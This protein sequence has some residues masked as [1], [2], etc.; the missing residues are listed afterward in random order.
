M[1]SD[2]WAGVVYLALK[3]LRRV[4]HFRGGLIMRIRNLCSAVF[5]AAAASTAANAATVGFSFDNAEYSN[6]GYGSF[7]G[8]DADGN[9]LLTLDELTSFSS[10]LPPES[11]FGLTLGDLSGF[12]S[13][14]L[15]TGIWNADGTGWGSSDFAWYSWNGDGNSV[16]TDWATMHITGYVR[17]NNVPEPVSLALFGLGLAALG[18]VRRKQ[19]SA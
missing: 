3:L 16:N 14:D 7:T 11:I 4:F 19:Q 13:F 10:D 18:V 1:Y 12:G 2:G 6:W 15:I 8:A 5:L 17:D 9:D